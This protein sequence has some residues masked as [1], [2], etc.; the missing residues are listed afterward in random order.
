MRR[1]KDGDPPAIF[2]GLLVA[3][4]VAGDEETESLGM[5]TLDE[6]GLSPNMRSQSSF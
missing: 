6:G 2:F 3:D 4:V 1:R 5:A